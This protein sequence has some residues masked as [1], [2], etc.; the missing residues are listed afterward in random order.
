[1]WEVGSVLDYKF[2]SGRNNVDRCRGKLDLVEKLCVQGRER[3]TA[4]EFAVTI[5]TDRII[6]LLMSGF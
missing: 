6:V 2:A 4:L 1:V 5:F 3:L